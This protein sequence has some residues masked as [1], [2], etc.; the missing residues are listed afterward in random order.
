[1][2]RENMAEHVSQPWDTLLK[3]VVGPGA[4]AF[5]SLVLPDVVVVGSLDKELRVT[6]FVGDLFLK[7][8]F[9]GDRSVIHFEFQ[10]KKGPKS[11]ERRRQ[12]GEPEKEKESWEEWEKKQ[13]V[14]DDEEKRR[15]R[16]KPMDRR[17][18]EYNCITDIQMECPVYSILVSLVPD[19]PPVVDSLYVREVP[20]TR[21]GHH[22]AYRV[23]NLWEVDGERLKSPECAD[24][25][26]L[27]PLTKGGNTP[28]VVEEMARELEAHDRLELL[29]LGLF[30]A[31]LVLKTKVERLWLIERF[32]LMDEESIL[33]DSW[34]YQLVLT[35][36]ES[37]GEARGRQQG[38]QQ[39]RQEGLQQG[40]LAAQQ[41]AVGIVKARFP[42]LEQLAAEILETLRDANRLQVLT[43]ELSVVSTP[44]Q[45]KALLLSIVAES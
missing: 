25:L 40:L 9:E 34:V 37:R 2:K 17:M 26:P 20:G 16:E 35:R 12:E 33:D 45:A 1:M 24:L 21:L 39:G 6:N 7:A 32:G 23:I 8:Y 42:E 29:P 22:F 19:G 28:G 27:L 13:V 18:W 3:L 36:G 5:A 14:A 15:K 38:L 11:E 10:K 31:G 30:C 44:E 43:I 41:T 4:Q